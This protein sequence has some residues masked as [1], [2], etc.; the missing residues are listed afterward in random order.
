MA[1]VSQM[2][3]TRDAWS[4]VIFDGD[5]DGK[6]YGNP[7]LETDAKIPAGKKLTIPRAAH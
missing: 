4:G 5:G 1:Q 6:V 7:T 2:K 3:R